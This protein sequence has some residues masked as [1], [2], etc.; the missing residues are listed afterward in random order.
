MG[1]RIIV[2]DVAA[3][4][5]GALSVLQNLYDYIV[6]N[7]RE[8]E[9]IFLLCQP[10]FEEKD[11]IKVIVYEEIKKSYFYRLKYDLFE[12]KRLEKIF[13]PDVFFSLQNI[14]FRGVKTKQAVY[15]H[16]SLP[17]QETMKFSPFKRDE[18]NLWFH[19]NIVGY[20]IKKSLPKADKVFVQS[21]WIKDAICRQL[22]VEEEKLVVAPPV[23]KKPLMIKK[24]EWRENAFFAPISGFKYKNAE[25]IEKAVALLKQRG[26]KDFSVDFSFDGKE[27]DS[28]VHYLGYLSSATMWEKYCGNT[29]IFPSYIETFGLPLAEAKMVGTVILAADL[30]YAREVL[31]G[32]DNAFFFNPSIPEELA[33][34]MEKVLTGTI[35][36][37][38]CKNENSQEDSWKKIVD[39]LS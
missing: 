34:L 12:G 8:N 14:P 32:Y 16:Q 6:E 7:D 36:K 35:K 10:F 9:W 28:T 38:E 30:P 2:S 39:C 3:K 11:N 25:C 1:M 4:S 20:F 18:V 37:G 15:M 29:V 33:T 31:E 19:T 17:F 24:T 27:S 23:V 5:G 21:R 22:K 26:F 13:E